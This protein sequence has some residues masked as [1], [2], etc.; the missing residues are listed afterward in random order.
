MQ[1]CPHVRTFYPTL[2]LAR[3]PCALQ[4]HQ[5]SH[6]QFARELEHCADAGRGRRRL[7]RGWAREAKFLAAERDEMEAK[8]K[9][10]VCVYRE[11]VRVQIVHEFPDAL[12]ALQ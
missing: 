2:L 4:A 5:L 12:S 8:V 7:R 11:G 6:P 1:I 9:N 3:D 10:V